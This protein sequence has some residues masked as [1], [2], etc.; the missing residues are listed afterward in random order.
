MR[1]TVRRCGR[2]AREPTSRLSSPAELLRPGSDLA[3]S[4]RV[5]PPAGDLDADR[6]QRR[7]LL[8]GCC[9]PCEP[10]RGLEREQLTPPSSAA[11]AFRSGP[12]GAAASFVKAP[13]SPCRRR[14]GRSPF[15]SPCAMIGRPPRPRFRPCTVVIALTVTEARALE[16]TLP[17]GA[18][19][20]VAKTSAD[21]ARCCAPR[22]RRLCSSA[23]WRRRCWA[24]WLTG[25]R[26]SRRDPPGLDA[27][28]CEVNAV[29]GVKNG[30]PLCQELLVAVL[31]LPLG[32]SAKSAG[33]SR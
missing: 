26:R 14:G 24:P 2:P 17:A 7:R 23:P 28:A 5:Q 11:W 13:R 20:S 9:P 22:I 10:A 8:V 18:G 4:S 6:E 25:S 16:K 19:S 1:S 27:D 15:D 3:R 31:A 33:R 30:G 21:S 12:A 32:A 29:E